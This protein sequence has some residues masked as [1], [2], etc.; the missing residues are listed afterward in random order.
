M[1]SMQLYISMDR[2]RS[3]TRSS[4]RSTHRQASMVGV[5]F[6][7]IEICFTGPF[8]GLGSEHSKSVF[9]LLTKVKSLPALEGHSD[10]VKWILQV[11]SWSFRSHR[12]HTHTHTHTLHGFSTAG[13]CFY[14]SGCW[15]ARCLRLWS[16]S[17]ILCWS[18]RCLRWWRATEFNSVL[19]F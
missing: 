3:S 4:G 9:Q 19:I 8:L 6:V 7:T 16:D 13:L 5:I 1:D 17:L 15:S 10:M 11:S 14:L 2:V 18:S 12:S